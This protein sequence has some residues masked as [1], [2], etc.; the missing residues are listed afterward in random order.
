M[1]ARPGSVSTTAIGLATRSRAPDPRPPRLLLLKIM[2][3]GA[4]TVTEIRR[5]ASKIAPA[6]NKG[7]LQYLPDD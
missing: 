3:E 5:K 1:E 4:S 6:S 7:A 2:R